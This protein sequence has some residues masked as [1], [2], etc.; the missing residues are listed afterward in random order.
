MK[1]KLYT[2][3][4]LI[5]SFLQTSSLFATPGTSYVVPT[6]P[7]TNLTFGSIEGNSLSF[8]WTPGNGANRIVIAR[9]DNPVTAI[10]VNG[11]DYFANG[12]FGSGNE[13]STG[14]FVVY[15][16]N[17]STFGM[18]GLI[19]N[20]TYH[21][22]IFEFNGSGF[23]TEYLT[24]AFLSGSRAT[25][26]VP[27]IQ[28]SNIT[29]S[30]VTGNSM[31]L[32]FTPGNGASRLI[33]AKANSPV[34]ANPT[35]LVS[36]FAGNQFGNGTQIGNGNFVIAIGSNA[37]TLTG[38]Q[39]STT[40][41]FAAFEF[42]GSTGPV[43]L[44]VNPALANQTTAPRPSVPSGNLTFSNVEGNTLAINFTTGNGAKRIVIAKAGSPVTAVPVDGMT[45]TASTVFGNGQQIAPGEFVMMDS[46]LS[47]ITLSNLQHST[48][49]HLA[50]FEYDGLGA[51]TA[52]LTSSFLAGS[53]STAVQPTIQTSNLSV[54]AITN[55]SITLNWTSGNGSERIILAKQ[56][57]PVNATPVTYTSYFPSLSFGSGT[58]IGTGNYVVYKG[59]GNTTTVT[60]LAFN[61]TYHFTVYELNGNAA[62]VYLTVSPPVA[63]ATTS[64][65]PSVPSSNPF[66]N[67]VEGNVMQLGW[68]PGNGTGRIIIAKAGSPVTAVPVNGMTYSGNTSFG[69]GFVIAPGEFV[70]SNGNS[71]NLS[72][73]NLSPGITYHLA[74]FE[75]NGSGSTTTYLTSSF[76]TTSR[77]TLAAPTIQTSNLSFSNI[78]SNSIQ[79][80]MTAGNG[81]NRLVLVKAGSPVDA[82]PADF[83]SYFPSTVF[84]NGAQI[85]SGNYVIKANSLNT[86]TLTGL[87]PNTTYHFA[88]FEYNGSSGPV[89]N[90]IAIPTANATTLPAPTVPASNV[91]F[92]VI[93]G[94][95]MQVQWVAGNGTKR[96]VVARQGSP[97][98]ALPL[99]GVNYTANIAFGAGQQISAGQYVVGNTASTG[100]TVTNLSPGTTYYFAVFEVDGTGSNTGYLTSSFATGN[101]STVSAPTVQTSNLFFTSISNTSMTLNWTNGN[102]QARLVVARAGSPVNAVP[103]DLTSYFASGNIAFAGQITPGNYVVSSTNG[104]SANVSGLQ[105][106]TTYHFAVYEFNGGFGPVYLTS[107]PATGNA[108]T[109]GAPQTQASN[110]VANAVNAGAATI[111]WTNGSGHKRIVLMRAN[112]AVNE[113]PA[114]GINYTPNTFFGSGSQLG[115][116]NYVVF[117]G[118]GNSVTVTNLN[119]TNTY[120]VAVIEYNNFGGTTIL[121]QTINPSTAV[122]TLSAP[123]IQSSN[124][125]SNAVTLTTATI[126]W[127]NGNGHKR[128]V[129]MRA[130]SAVNADPL[131]NTSYSPD[132]VFGS[133]SQ[134]GAGN[135]TVYNGTGNSITVSNLN[136]ATTYHVAIYEYNDFGSSLKR[137]L[138]INP[139]RTPVSGRPQIQAANA[140]V[141]IVNNT[142]VIV[143]WTSGS[144]HKRIVLMKA[145]G[146]VNAQPSDNTNYTANPSFGAGTQIGIGNYVVYSGTGNNVT[147][148]NL[149]AGTTYHIAV[150]EYNDFDIINKLYLTLDPARTS[151]SLGT[152][153]VRL[154]DFTANPT[155]KK[156]HLNW[157]TSEEHNSLR[158][159]IEKSID[160]ISFSEIGR[161]PAKGESNIRSN[162]SY[163]DHSPFDGNNYYRLKQVDRDGNHTYSPVRSAKFISIT[164]IR[165]VVNP[166]SGKLTIDLFKQPSLNAYL[167]I[168][169]LNGR[170]MK[171]EKISSVHI[172]TDISFL[173][174]GLYL[175]EVRD[176]ERREQIKLVKK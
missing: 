73:T 62:P 21:I 165:N 129:L 35:D 28:V 147:V 49:Y 127:S 125:V 61:T 161:V 126:S 134:I 176:S 48:T 56:G 175:L 23:S 162:Y 24:A 92:S 17:G 171:K 98:T 163:T 91:S 9:K 164:L 97:V 101:A 31:R 87:Q 100:I 60:N 78:I 4:V 86:V 138:T 3:V 13:I 118:T 57:S 119:L 64:G 30:Q 173:P 144:G 39:P 51:N 117:N 139:A 72:L 115:N 120:H 143:G 67:I 157:V 26:S 77:T 71:S 170:V 145:N 41:H 18:T 168:H 137:Y 107:S 153:P 7:S 82:V 103:A 130:G 29:I 113:S 16:G 1:S 124:P 76:L 53:R 174:N 90:R 2:Y 37:V 45:Y 68:S 141:N 102:G 128:I 69:S 58:Q 52:Y 15:K 123:Q 33:L 88:A 83:I 43:Y 8:S 111:T 96:L 109:V 40:Y 66:Y 46:S 44:A 114:D 34:D 150:F 84:G 94:N 95:S 135:Y 22:A 54:G 159:S 75:Y 50:V 104:S 112:G 132:T 14:Q 122:V 11:T 140:V 166:V 89:Y 93:Q 70:V 152:L 19:P 136:L 79:I 108:T 32:N 160:G 146:A 154:I 81:A 27:T 106:N 116:G 121:Y 55:N 151:V 99:N 167:V 148:T 12:T 59:S 156:I 80:N 142:S 172:E 5:F 105:P 65:A 36:Y 149:V 25:L 85:G 110:V 10:P 38:L 63:S 20:S 158:F 42:N 133:G 155:H 169:D 131:D 6:N 74:I 47:G